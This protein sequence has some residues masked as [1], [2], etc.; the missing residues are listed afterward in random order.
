MPR[1]GQKLTFSATRFMA[2][3]RG[4][5]SLIS[6]ARF[7]SSPFWVRVGPFLVF[8]LLTAL[9]GSSGERRFWVYLAKTV[10]GA[11][12]IWQVRRRIAEMRWAFSWEAILVG[13]AVF[14]V[15]VGFD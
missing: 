14:A 2:P 10:V 9:Q 11:A 7:R 5:V 6:N 15:W 12:M 4:M 1:F 8:V 3:M 13:I